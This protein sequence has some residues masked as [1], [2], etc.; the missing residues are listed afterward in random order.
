MENSVKYPFLVIEGN[1][2]TGKTSL[3]TKL[4]EVMGARLIL[5]QFADN[6]FLPGFYQ[7]PK[8]FAFPLELS[9]L[10]ERYQQLKAE[11][12]QHQLFSE[13]VVS[14]YLLTKSLIFARITL[15]EDEFSLY[16]K[17]FGIIH[18]FLPKPN[19]LVYLHKDVEL[20]QKNIKSR[21]RDYELNITD[22]YLGKIEQSYW[23]FFRQSTEQK[24]LV[25]DTNDLDFVNNADDFNKI[26]DVL[27]EDYP[28]GITRLLLK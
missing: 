10:A 5:E 11:L 13:N 27:K 28:L 6:P 21:G 2:G 3:S 23:D 18:N 9:F 16:K 1:I 14:D 25:L 19:L 20:L 26:L 17:L 15:E 4:A 24:I 8:R 7:E 22:E 12:S